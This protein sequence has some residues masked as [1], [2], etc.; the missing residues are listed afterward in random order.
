MTETG[1]Y[2]RGFRAGLQA[3][4]EAL[5]AADPLEAGCDWEDG[6]DIAIA[7]KIYLIQQVKEKSNEP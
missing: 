1:D 5:K 3:A 2:K 4:I 6:P 7:V